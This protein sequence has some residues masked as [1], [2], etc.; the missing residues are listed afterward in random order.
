MNSEASPII[1]PF[2]QPAL[3]IS[4]SYVLYVLLAAVYRLFFSPL[5]TVPG[6]WYA[7]VSGLWLKM[8]AMRLH[9][10]QTVH[11][12]FEKYGPIVRIAPD[13]IAFNDKEAARQVYNILRLDKSV[14]YKSLQANNN[15]HAMTTLPKA[16]HS[17]RKKTYTAH[18]NM[19]NLA[20]FEP[21]IKRAV[22]ELVDVLNEIRGHA[23]VDCLDLFRQLMVDTASATSF[24][25]QGSALVTWAWAFGSKVDGAGEPVNQ[26]SSA[27]GN[28]GKR[29]ILRSNF[30]T[31]AWSIVRRFPH[32]GWRQICNC[33]GIMAKVGSTG[34]SAF[35]RARPLTTHIQYVRTKVEQTRARMQSGDAADQGLALESEKACMIERLL[36]QSTASAGP[37]SGLVL[38]KEDVISETMGHLIAGVDTSSVTL[39]YLCWELSRRP[40]IVRHLR[41]ELE[42]AMAAVG[43][44]PATALETSTLFK[45]PYLNAFVKEGLRLYSAVPSLLERVVPP[46]QDPFILLGHTLP[47]GTIIA[48][49]PWS[50]HRDAAVFPDPAAFRPARW[51]DGMSEAAAQHMIPFGLGTRMCGGMNL[52][53]IVLRRVVAAVV[54]LFDIVAP[55]ETT[56]RTME[57]RDGFALFPA[58]MK[59]RLVF[60]PRQTSTSEAAPLL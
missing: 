4:A 50:M 5:R 13:K 2:G 14:F 47:P 57:M 15:D 31:W 60:I 7:A 29:A 54:L 19:S 3:F 56:E 42:H 53:Q 55:P 51:L 45:L 58:G 10:C 20:R 18:Y 48:T 8:H 36:A 11:Q 52:A 25:V 30:P 34:I 38:S 32:D 43:L 37:K 9:Q 6:P 49:Q 28:F 26:L 39:S 22:N 16:D 12:L 33:D 35:V 40:D 41:T 44:E 24:G 23:P 59:C 17:R 46:T 27:I 21:E 1:P